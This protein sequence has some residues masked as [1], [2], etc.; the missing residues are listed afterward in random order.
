MT[1]SV[2]SACARKQ[3]TTTIPIVVASATDFVAT[4]LV[5]PRGNV[6]PFYVLPVEILRGTRPVCIVIF[7]PFMADRLRGRRGSPERS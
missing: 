3:V 4:G 1:S 2:P 5:T 7:V 6:A